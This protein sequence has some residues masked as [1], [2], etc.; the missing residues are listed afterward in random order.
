MMAQICKQFNTCKLNILFAN[1]ILLCDISIIIVYYVI[2]INSYSKYHQILL[3]K[4]N[5]I[6]SCCIHILISKSDLTVLCP[7]SNLVRM[8]PENYKKDAELQ[9]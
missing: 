6:K 9:K 8:N 4:N 7:V 3:Q 1:I 2:I 5:K